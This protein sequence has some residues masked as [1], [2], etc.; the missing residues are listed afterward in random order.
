MVTLRSTAAS[1]ECPSQWDLIEQL[2]PGADG[3]VA[4]PSPVNGPSPDKGSHAKMKEAL[5]ALEKS[6]RVAD[7]FNG[8]HCHLLALVAAGTARFVG[9]AACFCRG[10]QTYRSLV[11]PTRKQAPACTVC[12][13]CRS[14]LTLR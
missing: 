11:V 2:G 10:P 12:I 14:D 8:K 5:Q 9:F 13:A 4:P 3:S 1:S 6:T 7:M